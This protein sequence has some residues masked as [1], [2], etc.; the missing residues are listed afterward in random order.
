VDDRIELDLRLGLGDRDRM[1]TDG[2]V[3]ATGY[4]ER[5]MAPLLGQLADRLRRDG[6]GRLA[7]DDDYRLLLDPCP[8]DGAIYLPNV[9]PRLPPHHPHCAPGPGLGA[10]RAAVVLNALC[11]RPVYRLPDRA[12]FSRFG[13]VR[14]PHSV[15]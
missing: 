4:R 6:D 1:L 7:V 13:L 14:Q 15:I 12:A 11:G 9:E 2:V 10:W 3:L 8:G 5:P